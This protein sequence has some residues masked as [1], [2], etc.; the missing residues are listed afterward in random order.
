M[1]VIDTR[2]LDGFGEAEGAENFNRIMAYID[3]KMPALKIQWLTPVNATKATGTL[4]LDTKPTA[5]DT[6]TIGTV[7]Y[8]F[9]AVAVVAGDIAIGADLAASKVNIVAAI[10]G[11]DGINTAHPVVTCGDF[12]ANVLTITAEAVGPDGNVTTTES[13]TAITNVFGAD[14]LEGGLN[15]TVGTKGQIMIDENK[16]YICTADNTIT[17]ANWKSATLT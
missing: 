8:T 14:T 11:T 1:P 3:S 2:L 17:D 10:K 4:T 13:F 7:V 5:N 16:I 6:M 9:K 15:G 12:V